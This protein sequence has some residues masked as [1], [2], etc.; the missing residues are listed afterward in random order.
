M[1]AQKGSKPVKYISG[2][3]VKVNIGGFYTEDKEFYHYDMGEKQ[4]TNSFIDSLQK[5]K[6]DI[7]K[8]VFLIIDK[9]SFHTSK[10]SKKYLDSN[11]SWLE[12]EYFS[13]AAPDRNPVEFCW[14]RTRQQL[15]QLY[16]FSNKKDLLINLE[17]LW[18]KD[19]FTHKISNYLPR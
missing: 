12:Y 5:F 6:K 1:W 10:E 4:N 8:K 9:A 14:K 19:F 16:S 11:N 13:T 17:K 7:N 18:K 2:T 3:K 15:L